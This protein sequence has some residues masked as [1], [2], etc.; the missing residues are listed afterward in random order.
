MELANRLVF[1]LH[2][3]RIVYFGNIHDH[4]LFDWTKLKQR[5]N[6]AMHQRPEQALGSIQGAGRW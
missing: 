3:N 1:D 6:Q 2:G 5:A 4:G